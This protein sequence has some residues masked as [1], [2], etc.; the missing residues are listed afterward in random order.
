[1]FVELG[2]LLE[3]NQN[4]D[5]HEGSI[6]RLV[7]ISGTTAVVAQIFRRLV[8]HTQY[9]E[10]L[11][12]AA[13]C[14][15][16]FQCWILQ[17][18]TAKPTDSSAVVQALAGTNTRNWSDIFLWVKI[19]IETLIANRVTIALFQNRI[20]VERFLQDQNVLMISNDQI[21]F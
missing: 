15:N 20:N 5:I 19:N 18:I 13:R 14:F 9:S 8:S 16:T 17:R 6:E 12:L 3:T 1:M 4:I 21:N 10:A 11:R 2:Y 7:C